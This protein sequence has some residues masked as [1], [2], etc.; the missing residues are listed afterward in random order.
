MI[1]V[2]DR[3]DGLLTH[4]HL[5]QFAKSHLKSSVR[6]AA[7]HVIFQ[8]WDFGTCPKNVR[9]RGTEELR[10]AWTHI[11]VTSDSSK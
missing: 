11:L 1:K 3:F 5:D 8:D 9:R 7:S 4:H 10:E 6:L 2:W